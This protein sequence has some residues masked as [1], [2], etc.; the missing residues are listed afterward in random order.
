MNSKGKRIG[1]LKGIVAFAMMLSII[2]GIIVMPV[3]ANESQENVQE[4]MNSYSE[5]MDYI[6]SDHDVMAVVYMCEQYEVKQDPSFASDTVVMAGIGQTVI[7]N[8]V[9]YDDDS[10]WFGVSL[11]VDD[12]LYEGYIQKDYLVYTDE[13]MLKLDN[14]ISLPNSRFAPSKAVSDIDFFPSSYRSYL[15]Q[16][17]KD[18]P[19]WTFVP[20]NT[21]LEWNEVVINEMYNDRSLVPANSDSTWIRGSYSSSWS[22][23]SEVILKYYLDPRNYLNDTNIFAFEQLTYNASYHTEAAVQNILNSTFMSGEIPNEGRSYANA[24]WDIGNTLGVSPFH[25]ACRVYQEQGPGTSPLISGTYG[26]YEGLYNF[27][28]VGASGSTNEAIYTSGLTYARNNGWTTRF[29]SLYG[30]AQVISR[31]YILKGQDTLYLQKFDVDS[32]YNGLYYHQYMQN[33]LAAMSESTNIKRAYVNANSVDNLF[34]FKIPVYNNMPGTR[35]LKPG[36]TEDVIPETFTVKDFVYRLY[37]VALERT[38]DADG[39]NTWIDALTNKT[40]TGATAAY[41]F[42]CGQEMTN[43]NYDNSAFLEVVYRTFFGREAD[44]SG[45]AAWL[46]M[47]DSGIT[48]DYVMKGF[49]DSIEFTALCE[50]YGIDRGTIELNNV[51]DL[52]VNIT[53]FVARCY[54]KALG[55]NY[56][57]SGLEAWVAYIASGTVTP[58][59]AAESFIYSQEFVQKNLSNE[60]YIAVLYRTFL[61]REPDAEGFSAWTDYINSGTVSREGALDGF[62]NSQEFASILASFGL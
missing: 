56:D 22:L 54:Q 34:V 62:A 44:A 35:C 39:Y 59:Q 32:S 20:M 10:V 33:I 36:E 17:K 31:N 4:I 43:R 52:H 21:G 53:Q 13:E 6:T 47:M 46:S 19:N 5:S 16:L 51:R 60:D 48:R 61:G 24:F 30:G 9:E 3:Y 42:L 12:K 26:G 7:V 49:I 27:F 1:K 40:V 23:A 50:K 37:T 8:S 14:E 25:L 18:H 11:S 15:T 58:K 2:M 38:P 57:I 45:K 41:S 29:A 55:R 28:N